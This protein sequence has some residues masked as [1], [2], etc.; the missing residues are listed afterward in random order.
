MLSA[1]QIRAQFR[2]VN[3]AHYPELA[4]YTWDEIY[5]C[6]DRMALG[7]LYLAAEMA[8]TIYH[9]YHSPDWWRDLFLASGIVT[10]LQ[11]HELAAGRLLWEDELLYSG[12]RA[13][14][15]AAYLQQGEWL[16][17]QLLY[18]RDHRPNLTHYIA[19]LEKQ[20]LTTG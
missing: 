5:G 12:E 1:T 16:I 19:L 15:S 17:K 14:W 8:R 3:K 4:A 18:G 9:K 20:E 7:G 6:G 13:S 10:M 2:R 11:C